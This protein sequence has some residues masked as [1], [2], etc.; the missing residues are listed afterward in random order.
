MRLSSGVR[1]GSLRF[2][3]RW[4]GSYISRL[5]LVPLRYRAMRGRGLT[6]ATEVIAPGGGASA[7][8]ALPLLP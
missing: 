4:P 5:R 1:P 6:A 8:V 3:P 7:W 2:R